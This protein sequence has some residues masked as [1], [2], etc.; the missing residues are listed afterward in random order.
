MS[1]IRLLCALYQICIPEREMGEKRNR[2]VPSIARQSVILKCLRQKSILLG[3]Y[4]FYYA[5]GLLKKLYQ[6]D[7][8]ADMKPEELLEKV[9]SV[10]DTL[11]A[12]SEQEAYLL[13]IVKNYRLANEQDNDTAVL[14][15][16]GASEEHLWQIQTDQKIE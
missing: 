2:M 8:S 3:N 1:D 5:A 4:E 13:H 14:F 11:T 15:A 9:L 6:L 7:I 10:I 12:Q 16:W